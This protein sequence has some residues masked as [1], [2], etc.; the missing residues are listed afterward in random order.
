M[1]APRRR[2]RAPRYPLRP[3]CIPAPAQDSR[4]T[5]SSPRRRASLSLSAERNRHR[6]YDDPSPRHVSVLR[7]RS[8][9]TRR[10]AIGRDTHTHTRARV[11]ARTPMPGTPAG[12]TLSHSSDRADDRGMAG[13]RRRRH[14]D[15]GDGV[16]VSDGATSTSFTA[17]RRR[18]S[19]AET[20][21]PPRARRASC[22]AAPSEP[23]S[24]PL[25]RNPP[26]GGSPFRVRSRYR[27]PSPLPPPASSSGARARAR[28]Q[29]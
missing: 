24:P 16:D 20:C 14:G 11:R 25:A 3:S 4:F 13:R 2:A 27:R 18:D 23:P 1:T 19:R 12:S 8:T 15:G 21:S 17:A 29:P 28:V 9:R 6:L 7:D 26:R 5:R 22:H 10:S